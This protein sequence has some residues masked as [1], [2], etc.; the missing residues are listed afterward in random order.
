MLATGRAVS[1]DRFVDESTVFRGT[2]HR[3]QAPASRLGEGGL[4][5]AEA[6]L[7]ETSFY[8]RR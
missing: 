7:S 1:H 6:L 2:I 8:A 5:P 3:S 4:A